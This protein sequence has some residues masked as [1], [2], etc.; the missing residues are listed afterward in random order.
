[1]RLIVL[2]T[3]VIVSA[4]IKPTGFPARIIRSAIQE[5][6]IQIVV[7]PTIVAEYRRVSQYSKFVQYDFPPVWLEFLIESALRFPDGTAWPHPLPDRD[8][9]CFLSLA[10]TTGAWLITGNVKHYP[11]GSRGGVVVRM[12][13]EYVAILDETLGMGC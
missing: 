11:A 2:D 4:G 12:P 6:N 3:N 7:S 9:G 10:K 13:A 5:A 1:M 8:D